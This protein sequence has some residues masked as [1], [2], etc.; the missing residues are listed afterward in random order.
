[1]E[2][3]KIAIC[4][5]DRMSMEALKAIV[6][7]IIGAKAEFYEYSSGEELLR[8]IGEEHQLIIPLRWCRTVI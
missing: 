2:K 6:T 1:M 5:D 3:Y 7:E 4:D 8:N